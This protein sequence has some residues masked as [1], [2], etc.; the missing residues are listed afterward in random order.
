MF[1]VWCCW[2]SPD[3]PEPEAS[4][5]MGKRVVLSTYGLLGLPEGGGGGGESKKERGIEEGDGAV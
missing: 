5:L 4:L 2:P 3:P 1:W